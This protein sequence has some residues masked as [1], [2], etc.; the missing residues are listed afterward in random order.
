MVI[1][2]LRKRVAFIPIF[3]SQVPERRQASTCIGMTGGGSLTASSSLSLRLS[4][5]LQ[6]P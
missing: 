4:R 6:L 5:P 3:L 1:V 2:E